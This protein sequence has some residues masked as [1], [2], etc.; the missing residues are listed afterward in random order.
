MAKID[1]MK[2]LVVFDFDGTLIDSPE[3]EEGKVLW[4]E[5]III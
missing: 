2:R 1:I 4:S 3:A 5:K